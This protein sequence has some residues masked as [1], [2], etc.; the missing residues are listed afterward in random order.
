TRAHVRIKLG[1]LRLRL[2]HEPAPPLEIKPECHVVG[3][4]VAAADIDVEPALLRPEDEVE[5]VVLEPLRIGEPHRQR[6]SC[7]RG[8]RGPAKP[9]MSLCLRRNAITAA[10]NASGSSMQQ[11]CPVPFSTTCS[12]PLI[13]AAVALP[14]GSELSCAPLMTRVGRRTSPRR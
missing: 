10:S 12:E 14:A 6:P 1:E 3:D 2:D 9:L 11:A 7:L 8:R 5:M 13:P 4:G